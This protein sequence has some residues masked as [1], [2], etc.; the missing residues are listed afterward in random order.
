MQIK[1]LAALIAIAQIAN[2]VAAD[3]TFWHNFTTQIDPKNVSVP[4]ITQTTSIN[5]SE[6][7]VYYSPD[8]SLVDIVSAEWPTSWQKATTNG[9]NETAEF[10]AMYNSI[11]W[12]KAPNIP[13]RTLLADGSLNMTGYSSSSDPDCWWSASGCT[14]PKISDAYTDLVQCAEPETWGLTYDDGPNCSHNAF[15][16]YL[17]EQKLKATMFYIGSNVIDWPYGAMRGIQDGHH[18]A[19]HTWSHPMITTFT[20]QEVLAEFYFSLKAIKLATGLTPRYWRPPYG[21]IDDRVRWIAAQL[22][23]TAVMWNLDTDD[24][25]AGLTKTVADV[26]TA[27]DQFIQMGKNGT[28]AGS[29]NIVLAH[30]INNETM[31]LAIQNLPSIQ[32]AYKQVINVA[33]CFNISQPYFE[34]YTWLDVLNGTAASSTAV[35]GVPSAQ[36]AAKST[37]TDAQSSDASSNAISSIFALFAVAL[38]SLLS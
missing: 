25:A 17:E 34:D 13:V 23:L 9:M 27:Y 20:N 8:T 11:D 10:I 14:K 37:S 3:L 24:W 16:D 15:Y 33:T 36:S 1:T 35:S 2:E 19:C 30:E 32:A 5:P 18:I 4:S 31:S 12:T 38:G 22:G 28:F 29:G 6:E 21:D 26:Q 7:C